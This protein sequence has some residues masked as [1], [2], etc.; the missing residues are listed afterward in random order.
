MRIAYI[1][2]VHQN[3]SQV[4]RLLDRLT[5]E[6]ATFV[7][8]G[9]RRASR[10]DWEQIVRGAAKLPIV[11]LLDRHRCYWGGF[12]VVRAALKGI[13]HLLSHDAPFDY[14]VLQRAGLPAAGPRRRSNA[15]STMRPD[16]R[17]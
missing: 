16:D 10:G 5:T 7:L 15:S 3:P 12:G 1:L 8:H 13:D 17:S 6:G 9:D 14:A 11:A 2:P 4:L